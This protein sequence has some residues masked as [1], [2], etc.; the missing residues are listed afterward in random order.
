MFEMTILEVLYTDE[1]DKAIM[2][3]RDSDENNFIEGDL[4][5]LINEET[6]N[7]IYC[8][9]SIHDSIP[10]DSISLGQN[11]MDG[12]GLAEND[13]VSISLCKKNITK[14]K[15]IEIEYESQEFDPSMLEFDENFRLKLVAYLRKYYYNQINEIYWPEY[16]ARLSISFPELKNIG[17]PIGISD[18]NDEIIIKIRPKTTLSPFNAILAIDCSGSMHRKDIKFSRMSNILDDLINIYDGKTTQHEELKE[19]LKSLRPKFLI[20]P[21]KYAISRID[22]TLLAILMFFNQKIS[23]GLGEKCSILLYSGRTKLFDLEGKKTIFNATDMANINVITNLKSQITHSK[24]LQLNH[25]IFHRVFIQLKELIEQ[26]SEISKNPI[27]ILLL[28]DGKPEPKDIDKPE[29]IDE[30]INVLRSY[31]RQKKQQFAIFTLGIGQEDQVDSDL[32]SRIAQLGFGEYHFPQDLLELTT[33][34]ENLAKEF[35][36]SLQKIID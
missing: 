22:A 34:F 14:A 17:P 31:A 7:I 6:G 26:Y 12:L 23:R 27:M 25:T 28:T 8:I 20:D 13:T 3:S 30:K 11:L 19:Y 2:N 18:F 36:I 15:K 33:W 1:I 24:D 16:D 9:L 35:S 29:L 32:L 10:Q 5:E 4:L 21:E